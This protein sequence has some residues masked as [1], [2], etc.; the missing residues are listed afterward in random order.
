MTLKR[1]RI[2]WATALLRDRI[3]FSTAVSTICMVAFGTGMGLGRWF[4]PDVLKRAPLDNQLKAV[5]VAQFI[6]FSDG[7]PD[8]AAGQS[9]YASGLAIAGA[10]F[11]LG[12]LGD[13]LGIS[14]AYLMVPILILIAL[15]TIIAIPSEQMTTADKV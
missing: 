9:S 2:F 3:G 8:L 1:D 13:H 12:F 6:G 4:G 7:R 10:P 14:R 15:T 11:L 5:M